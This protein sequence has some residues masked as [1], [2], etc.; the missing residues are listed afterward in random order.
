M[1]IFVQESVE[2]MIPGVQTIPEDT[3]TLVDLNYK[4]QSHRN[5]P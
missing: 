4:R 2:G 1:L 3:C 5:P